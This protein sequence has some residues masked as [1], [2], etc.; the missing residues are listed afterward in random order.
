MKYIVK[1]D[2]CNLLEG[3]EIDITIDMDGRIYFNV[4]NRKQM[5]R[6]YGN[7]KGKWGKD[8]P[9]P[10]SG[11]SFKLIEE[12]IP[13]FTVMVFNK[14]PPRP[15]HPTKELYYADNTE[16]WETK[17]MIKIINDLENIGVL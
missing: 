6:Y 16:N 2:F 1:K 13:E 14:I 5:I 8:N 4:S 3:D 15:H 12:N 17:W 7:D 10:R 9:A 11:P